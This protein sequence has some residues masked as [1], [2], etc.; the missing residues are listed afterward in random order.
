MRK[1]KGGRRQ[2]RKERDGADGR[3]RGSLP[4]RPSWADGPEG[5]EPTAL[6]AEPVPSK[7]SREETAVPATEKE[8]EKTRHGLGP[9]SRWAPASS[10]LR[11]LSSR[12]RILCFKSGLIGSERALA[13][14]PGLWRDPSHPRPSS[15]PP[16]RDWN[17]HPPPTPPALVAAPGRPSQPHP[18]QAAPSFK[19]CRGRSAVLQE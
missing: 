1:S 10:C 4:E 2:E 16:S 14:T 12:V 11:G 19:G 9:P 8:G 7:E 6:S 17:S 3:E 13:S 5:S 15:E 18:G